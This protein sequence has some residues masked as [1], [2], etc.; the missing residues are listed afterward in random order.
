[1]KDQ[2]YCEIRNHCHYTGEHGGA[3]HIICNS[4]YSA[5]RKIFIGFHI[6]SNYNYHFII[7]QLAEEF[8]TQFTCLG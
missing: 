8:K 3:A 7:R 5:P 2:I 4:K 1:M 6:G